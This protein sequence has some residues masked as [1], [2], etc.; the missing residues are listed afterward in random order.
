VKDKI[1]STL[2]FFITISPD[3]ERSHAD[4][5]IWQVKYSFYYD[6]L[7]GAAGMSKKHKFNFGENI[8][9]YIIKKDCCAF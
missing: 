2:E 1:Q 4:I 5:F 9:M 7:L 6:F 3:L 8:V